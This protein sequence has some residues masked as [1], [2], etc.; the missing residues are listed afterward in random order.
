MLQ[1]PICGVLGKCKTLQSSELGQ[2]KSL[3]T[4]GLEFSSTISVRCFLLLH[5]TCFK[6]WLS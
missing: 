6:V 1:A 5:L 4:L 2:L 3:I